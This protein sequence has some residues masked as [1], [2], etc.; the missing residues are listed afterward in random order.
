MQALVCAV[1]HGYF[2]R[3]AVKELLGQR[4]EMEAFV[5]SPT[6]FNAIAKN[7]DTS[8]QAFQLNVC[9]LREC[10]KRDELSRNG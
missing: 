4:M 8:E 6:L 10:Y 1:E 5:D 2:V 7:S 9:A 3:E